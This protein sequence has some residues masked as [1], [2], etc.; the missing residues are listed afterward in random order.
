A[1]GCGYSFAII[2]AMTLA[3]TEQ[4]FAY[5]REHPP[6]YLMV[7]VIARLLGWKPPEPAPPTFDQLLAAPPPG[8]AVTADG[9]LGMPAPVLDIDT[10]RLRNRAHLAKTEP[11]S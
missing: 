8:L 9:A 11:S 5:W 6:V 10:L 7:E 3:E 4:I 1:T 2:D